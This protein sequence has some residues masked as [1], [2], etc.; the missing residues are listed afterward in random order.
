M[1]QELSYKGLIITDSFEMG[2]VGQG[3]LEAARR[4][5]DAGADLVIGPSIETEKNRMGPAPVMRSQER[6]RLTDQSDATARLLSLE[7]A[8]SSIAWVSGRSCAL[9]AGECRNLGLKLLTETGGSQC[10]AERFVSEVFDRVPGAYLL[11]DDEV[12]DSDEK[13]T[14]V[15]VVSWR[16]EKKEG[17]ER[18]LDLILSQLDSRREEIAVIFGALEIA[19]GV[20][21][22]M[23]CILCGD[24]TNACQVAAAEA[25]FG[26]ISL[27]GVPDLSIDH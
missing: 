19:S 18:V 7:V 21:N 22:R 26:E 14:R 12:V 4:A 6:E 11:K 1:C 27:S 3:D 2:G 25:L 13:E 17:A 24:S 10:W 16:G 20:G 23:P 8:R 9:L 5:I 15:F